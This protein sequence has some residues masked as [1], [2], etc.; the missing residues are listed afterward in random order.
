LSSPRVASARLRRDGLD[1][2]L[3]SILEGRQ[4]DLGI[5]IDS[6]RR[7]GLELAFSHGLDLGTAGASHF[8]PA[9]FAPRAPRY[10]STTFS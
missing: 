5:G 7:L 2:Q 8:D 1:P 10:K 6:G 4:R 3:E 9:H